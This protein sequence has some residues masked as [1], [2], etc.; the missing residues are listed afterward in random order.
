[1]DVKVIKTETRSGEIENYNNHIVD[2]PT[3]QDNGTITTMV[4]W[5]KIARM[6][7]EKTRKVGSRTSINELKRETHEKQRT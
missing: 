1:M 5:V 7:R 2:H 3:N 4:M 6:F